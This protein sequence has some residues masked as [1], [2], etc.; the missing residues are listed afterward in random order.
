M[1]VS[2]TPLTPKLLHHAFCVTPHSACHDIADVADQLVK[3][4]SCKRY[5]AACL[6]DSVGGCVGSQSAPSTGKAAEEPLQAQ[7]T[8][9]NVQP[10]AQPAPSKA[11]VQPADRSSAA[12]PTRDQHAQQQGGVDASGKLFANAGHEVTSVVADDDDSGDAGGE[13]AGRTISTTPYDE[14]D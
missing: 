1:R 8:N 11:E 14:L 4:E 5:D 6:V 2:V 9:G 12:A 7:S 13:G 10:A 3:R